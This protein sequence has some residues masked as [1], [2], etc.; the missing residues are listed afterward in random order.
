MR[1][2]AFVVSA[3]NSDRDNDLLREF[4]DLRRPFSIP[5]HGAE[6]ASPCCGRRRRDAPS[7]EEKSAESP[8]PAAPQ[9]VSEA[10]DSARF[11]PSDKRHDLRQFASACSRPPRL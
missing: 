9:A 5:G 4:R 10:L 11:Y 3:E 7:R 1:I 2:S 6:S 8:D